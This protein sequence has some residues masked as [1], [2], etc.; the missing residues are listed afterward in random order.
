MKEWASICMSFLFISA[1]VTLGTCI[2]VVAEQPD[3]V[4]AW[5]LVWAY[6]VF[7]FSV[8]A[9]GL[10]AAVLGITHRGVREN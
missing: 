8:S 2:V 6:S 1:A 7:I 5:V 4:N 3:G 10:I 9:A